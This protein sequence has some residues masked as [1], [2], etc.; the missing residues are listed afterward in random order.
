[1]HRGLGLATLAAGFT[2]PQSVGDGLI[3]LITG[4]EKEKLPFLTDDYP[5]WDK[6]SKDFI[7]LLHSEQLRSKVKA[8]S[9]LRTIIVLH[10]DD[11]TASLL[12]DVSKICTAAHLKQKLKGCTAA[13]F[14]QVLRA[15]GLR[16]EINASFNVCIGRD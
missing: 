5:W 4:D 9:N 15:M 8:L 2:I 11:D 10:Q 16:A 6:A 13:Q 7:S 14:P 3:D 12:K 1:M